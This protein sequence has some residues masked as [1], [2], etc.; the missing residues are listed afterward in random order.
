MAERSLRGMKIGANSLESDK[1]IAF[2][3]RRE[4]LYK[5]KKGHKFTVTFA[6][7]AE[8]PGLWECK[9]GAEAKLVGGTVEEEKKPVKPARTHWDML[10]ER[11]TIEELQVLLDQRLE[12]LRAGKLHRR[13]H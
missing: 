1:G 9:C 8:A 2:V 12:L 5:C 6:A 7:D 4:E 11:R 13:H 10:L 3:E